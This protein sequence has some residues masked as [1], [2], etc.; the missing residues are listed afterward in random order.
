MLSEMGGIVVDKQV[1]LTEDLGWLEN[2]NKINV[3]N[4]GKC[5]KPKVVGYYHINYTNLVEEVEVSS[6]ET[7]ELHLYPPLDP[8]FLAVSRDGVDFIKEV[9]KVYIDLLEF[10]D[11]TAKMLAQLK[12]NMGEIRGRDPYYESYY[13]AFSSVLRKKQIQF[14]KEW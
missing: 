2:F 8:Y 14:D 7:K 5:D 12:L 1:L 11:K 4:K 13:A 10:P 3:N 9:I 6:Y